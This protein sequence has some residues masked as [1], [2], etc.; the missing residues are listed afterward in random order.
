MA[1]VAPGGGIPQLLEPRRRAAP[2][3]TR[4]QAPRKDPVDDLLL[5]A[6]FGEI[7]VF[8]IDEPLDQLE[9]TAA[10]NELVNRSAWL[11]ANPRRTLAMYNSRPPAQSRDHIFW[12]SLFFLAGSD[13]YLH[14][15][16]G[17][18]LV[19][20][21]G[22]ALVRVLTEDLA[23]QRARIRYARRP[24][25]IARVASSREREAVAA[26]AARRH[27]NWVCGASALQ[28]G[29]PHDLS[30]EDL[31]MVREGRLS[32]ESQRALE[33]AVLAEAL[34]RE[35][36]LSWGEMDLDPEELLD[37]PEELRAGGAP[38]DDAPEELRAGGAPPDPPTSTYT[39]TPAA[40]GPPPIPGLWPGV[41]GW[42]TNG[43]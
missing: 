29:G 15:I 30:Q 41:L 8:G 13:Y 25:V 17:T 12:H 4:R 14:R 43:E 32:T 6:G 28:N 7:D 27:R 20:L 37:A 31:Q 26:S 35:Y 5:S 10:I 2:D 34:R 11:S 42:F 23:H 19:N 33:D 3:W 39:T 22:A 38:P 36:M 1:R 16:Y 24:D 21:S 18:G 9:Q 40:S